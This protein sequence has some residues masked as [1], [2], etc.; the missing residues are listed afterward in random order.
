MAELRWPLA[1]HV[2]SRPRSRSMSIARLPRQV[3]KPHPVLGWVLA[4]GASVR[5][6]TRT[7]RDVVQRIDA[8]GWRYVPEPVEPTDFTLGI[9][10]CSFI[11]GTELADDE[12]LAARLQN[13]MNNVRISNRGVGGYGT[14]QNYLQFRREIERGDVDAA[15]FGVVSD[16]RFRN[17]A[18]PQKM[19]QHFSKIWC[20]LGVEHLPR[21]VQDRHG[22]LSIEYVDIWQ[23]SLSRQ[24]FDVFLP[25]DH[26]IDQATICVLRTI[27]S[28][29][30][31]YGVPVVIALLDQLDMEFNR[32]I[33]DE[34]PGAVDVSTP[35]DTDH[36]FLPLDIHPNVH[37][38]QL[39]A[40]RLS[41]VVNRICGQLFWNS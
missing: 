30:A 1:D 41:P 11:Y 10:G 14:V 24:N 5:A 23:P 22:K 20:E 2:T 35:Y 3:F 18:H 40:D 19:K 4:P 13:K 27:L 32:L 38:N 31:E 6:R 28:L 12:T 26:M 15:V 37:A 16:H 21:A 39:F 7:D 36:T 29:S 8:S 34:I 33:M 9:Y 25:N 17:I